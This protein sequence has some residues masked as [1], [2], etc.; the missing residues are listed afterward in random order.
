MNLLSTSWLKIK[1]Q[2][3][4]IETIAPYQIT[5]NYQ[6]DPVIDLILPRSDFRGAIIQFLIGL[7]QTAFADIQPYQ[8]RT[9][10]KNPPSPEELKMKF[11]P[12]IKAFAIDSNGPSFM[13]DLELTGAEFKPIGSLLLEQPGENTLKILP[14]I[15][16]NGRR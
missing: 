4:V 7:L 9:W 15:S 16:S 10:R 2:S 1:R 8:W 5:E 6:T 11:A 14:I 13:Q 3:G 12:F